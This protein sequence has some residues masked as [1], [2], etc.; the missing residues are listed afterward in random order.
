[1]EGFISK[2]KK[3]FLLF[4]FLI[5]LFGAV[6]FLSYKFVRAQ[7][8]QAVAI[9][10]FMYN[11]EGS[12]DKKEWLEIENQTD[13][14]FNL[15][16]CKLN[17]GSSHILNAPPKNGGQGSLIIPPRGFAVLADDAL[18]F[19][20][21]Y[22]NVTVA[23]IDSS[24]SLKNSAGKIVLFGPAGEELSVVDY[25]PAVGGNGDGFSLERKIL[26]GAFI[27]QVS[28]NLGG[29]PGQKNSE[30]L[31]GAPA[32][33]EQIASPTAQPET[34]LPPISP[35]DNSVLQA[36]AGPDLV[37]TVNQEITFDAKESQ[38]NLKYFFWNFGDGSTSTGKPKTTHR[39]KFPGTYFVSLTVGDGKTEATDTCRVTVF[40]NSFFIS[41]FL[42]WAEQDDKNNEW[43]E[44][45]NQSEDSQLLDG[46]QLTDGSK[47]KP[48]VFPK[49][50]LIAPKSYLVVSRSVTNIALNNNGDTL[51]LLFPDGSLAQEI[52]YAKARKGFSAAVDEN[53]N[54][55]WTALKTPSN[56]NFSQAPNENAADQKPISLLVRPK[57][58]T[59]VSL[60]NQSFLNLIP[61]VQAALVQEPK[62]SEASLLPPKEFLFDDQEKTAETDGSSPDPLART[63]NK[64]KALK[65]LSDKNNLPLIILFVSLVVSLAIFGVWLGKI[66]KK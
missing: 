8:N 36:E 23:V 65:T 24:F 9:S 22:P 59:E 25:D 42:P 47:N 14:P 41:E 53:N 35:P 39:Y 15:E 19:K 34:T 5:P 46:W 57:P 56:P 62:D 16:G 32:P 66:T 12:D 18:T 13:A 7:T 26:N 11:P 63:E 48:F 3:V 37:A 51:K 30:L 17:D 54:F 31:T 10:E 55:F 33:E 28:Q 4:C 52:K 50:S 45:Y 44:I 38:G 64:N 6:V 27:W 20:S 60:K 49:K 58:T 40:N 61:A 29:T 21:L 43:I 2:T 1:M